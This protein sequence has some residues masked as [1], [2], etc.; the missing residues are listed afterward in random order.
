MLGVVAHPTVQLNNNL[1]IRNSM[2]PAMLNIL[3]IIADA[4]N[5]LL[6]LMCLAVCVY[7][8]RNGFRLYGLRLLAIAVASYAVMFI[9]QGFSLWSRL[10]LDF[11]THTA[12]SLGM[13]LFLAAGRSKKWIAILL[14]SLIAYCWIMYV[15]AYHTWPDMVS[16][17]AVMSGL[18]FVVFKLT[19][20]C[21]IN[22]KSD[23]AI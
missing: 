11:S 3:A 14:S 7:Q 12:T 23:M 17:L 15:E 21:A 2:S 10:G 22:I 19:K 5:P 20:K 13:V 9:D 6:L 1:D 16:T 8:W 4:Y 18:F